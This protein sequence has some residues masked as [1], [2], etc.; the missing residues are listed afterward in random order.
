MTISGYNTATLL[1]D[2][3]VLIAGRDF[4]HVGGIVE[5]YDPVA[6]VFTEAIGMFP[7]SEEG[8]TT[9]LLADGS[10]LLAG[11]WR[12]CGFSVATAE[13]YRP[14][15]ATPPPVLYSL[16]GGAQGAILHAATH[17]VV[18]PAN[19]AVA[20]EAIE[21]YGAGLADGSSIPP[22][23][24]IGGRLAELLYFGQ[25]PGFPG[26]NQINV[27]APAGVA[28][29]PAVGVRLNYLARPSNEVTVAVQ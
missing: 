3:S 25:A 20:G 21:I 11:G 17:E 22:Q 7:Q 19:P 27:R 16:S 14:T 5:L 18:S 8:H 24:A 1:P 26:L 2:G 13:V 10:V 12:C 23:V 29:G 4:Q 28:P 6:D 15:H 9:T